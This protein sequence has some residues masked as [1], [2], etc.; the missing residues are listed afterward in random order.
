MPTDT[1][2]KEQAVLGG[3]L[4]S[5]NAIDEVQP[6][7]TKHHFANEM[8]AQIFEACLS[9]REN[10]K[11]ADA[12][13]VAT[14]LQGDVPDPGALTVGIS[15]ILE[16][17]P[18]AAHT[19]HYAELVRESHKRR[20][21]LRAI[22][23]AQDEAKN[24]GESTEDIIAKVE[25]QLHS[26][27]EDSV[28]TGA[29][30]I[31]DSLGNVFARL[32]RKDPPG[33]PMGWS[34]LDELYQLQPGHLVYVAARPSMGKTGLAANVA[35]NVAK[36][37]KRVLFFSLEQTV[38]EMAARFLSAW[39][40]ISGNQINRLDPSTDAERMEWLKQSSALSELPIDIDDDPDA[41]VSRI[42]AKSRLWKRRYGLDLLI[43]DYL[44]LIDPED[45]KVNREQQVATMSRKLKKL[46]GS[47]EVPVMCLAQLNRESERTT[48]K[49][50]RLSNLRE[51]GSLE[52]D[53]NCVMLIHRPEFYDHT[54]RPGEADVIVEKNR[55]GETGTVKLQFEKSTV[56]FRDLANPMDYYGRSEW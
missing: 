4:L 28:G 39:G 27:L 34:K 2:Q 1:L 24:P 55:N 49:V 5:S 33:L 13:T 15:H 32:D 54:D 42:A 37:G 35:I 19:L 47:L 56:T 23:E 3:M 48:S 9:L 18:H 6:I 53:A 31:R 25:S 7:L 52:Q 40:Q 29:T 38:T 36:R 44:Q 50:P 41:T 43:V 10:G 51:S 20:T 26:L 12:V 30:S 22:R 17:V 46:A 45:T 21:L 8:H 11:P 16:T 14:H